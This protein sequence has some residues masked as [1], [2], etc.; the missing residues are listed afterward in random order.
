MHVVFS[1][2][3]EIHL[4]LLPT[5]T[6]TSAIFSS[7]SHIFARESKGVVSVWWPQVRWPLWWQLAAGAGE[8]AVRCD[9]HQQ[10]VDWLLANVGEPMTVLV[11]GSRSSAM[12]Q[13]V[14]M[15]QEK[16]NH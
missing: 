8:P 6:G 9:N 14:K 7:S 1:V 3:P 4:V 15:L 11:K 13:V 10:A 5:L 2:S 12:D 16:V